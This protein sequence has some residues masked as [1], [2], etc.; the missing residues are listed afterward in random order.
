M[1]RNNPAANRPRQISQSLP[2][3]LGGLNARDALQS[4][5]ATDALE[6]VNWVAQQYGVRTRKGWREWATGFGAPVRTLM[7]YQPNREALATF[8]I[9][10][11]TDAGIYDVTASTS[12][13]AVSLALPGTDG[14]GYLSSIQIVQAGGSFLLTCS[15][16]GGYRY[17]NGTTWTTPAFGTAAGQVGGIDPSNLV[18]VTTWKSKVWF[19]EKNSSNAWYLPT[20][21]ITGVAK[22]IELGQFFTRGGKLAFIATWTIDAGEGIDDFIVFA[23]ENGEVLIYKGTDPDSAGAFAKVG[24]FYVGALPVGRRGF[25][26]LGG[27]LLILSELG[28]QPLSYVTRGGQSLLRSSSVDYLAKIQPRLAELVAQ[29]SNTVGWAMTFFPRESFMIVDVPVGATTEYQQYVLYTNTNTWSQF[30][31]IPSNGSSCVANNQLF[32]GTDD[33]RVCQAHTG[34]FDNVPLGSSTGNGIYGK[35]QTAYNYFGQPGANKQ[36]LMVRPNFQATDRPSVV[37]T[38]LADFQTAV[39]QGTPI[40]SAPVGARWD[41]SLWDQARWAGALQ[42]FADWYGVE[43]LGYTGSLVMDTVCPGDTFLASIDYSME[44][45]GL[46]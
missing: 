39:T 30:K 37:C 11:A 45:G 3:P 1:A 28:I 2:A 20:N 24:T 9:F 7:T 4:M 8:R 35:I 6:L 46:L 15:H 17:Y 33:G 42:S 36:F 31:S 32:F 16:Q 44:R 23:S 34:Y 21:Q 5:P 41:V 43:A 22:K 13:P 27:D 40:S 14:Y 38:M 10:A 29:Y 26:S 18:F 25:T 12:A 19:I